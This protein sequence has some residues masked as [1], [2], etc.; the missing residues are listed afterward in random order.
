MR[1]NLIS[2]ALMAINITGMILE[3]PLK[4]FSLATRVGGGVMIWG[5][6]SGDARSEIAILQG[7]QNAEAYITTLSDYLMPFY[8][9]FRWDEMQFMQDGAAIHRAHVVSEFFDE[10]NIQLFDHPS[11]SPDLNPIENVWGY[12]ARQVYINGKQYFS[13]NELITSIKEEWAKIPQNIIENCVKSMPKRCVEVVVKKGA[14]T[15]Y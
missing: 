2:M 1:R 11:L 7:S 13:K 15:K 14:K 6:I 4:A 9:A 8:H 12:L 5:A 3:R 10:Q